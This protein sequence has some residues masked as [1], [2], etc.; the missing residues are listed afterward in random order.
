MEDLSAIKSG[1]DLSEDEKPPMKKVEGSDEEVKDKDAVVDEEDEYSDVIDE[2]PKPKR[3]KAK[4]ESVSKSSA[5][6]KASKPKSSGA[7]DSEEGEIKKLQAQLV[8][9]G[10]RKLW[11]N[12]LKR[13]GSDSRAKIRH[14]KKMLTDV[15]MDG[16]FSEA[17]AREIK[18]TRELLAEA[19]AAQE[20]NNLWGTGSEGRASRSKAKAKS[21]KVDDSDDSEA[22]EAKGPKKEEDD[23]DDEDTTFAARRRAR[24]DLAFLGDD[25]DSD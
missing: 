8:K 23:E 12:E 24:A 5:S 18:E 25:S 15:G 11:Q 13:Y 22:D 6:A 21:M 14:L 10:V 16:R 9:C 2:A 17:K 20:M 19:E 3:K 4:S 1:A 7:D